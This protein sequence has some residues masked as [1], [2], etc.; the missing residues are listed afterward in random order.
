MIDT[1]SVALP[2]IHELWRDHRH[3]CPFVRHDEKGCFCTSPRMPAGGDA[4]M[5]C[6]VY[7]LQ[8]WCLDEDHYTRCNFWPAGDVP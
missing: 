1:Q 3:A 2:L 5:P 8:I 6:D 7:S 4:Y